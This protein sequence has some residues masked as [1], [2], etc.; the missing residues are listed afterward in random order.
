MVATTAAIL[1][2]E[3]Q[4]REHPRLKIIPGDIASV[5]W[6]TRDSER[7][8]DAELW[9]SSVAMLRA[10]GTVGR[11]GPQGKR[12]PGMRWFVCRSKRQRAVTECL[13]KTTV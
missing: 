4:T 9:L 10:V 2:L 7:E 8:R 13:V 3:R 1:T 12:C 6:D 5:F 11:N